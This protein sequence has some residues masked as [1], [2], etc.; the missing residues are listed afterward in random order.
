[1]LLED[2]LRECRV[3]PVVNSPD[4]ETTVSL[5]Q[6]LAAGG[7]KG[8]EITLRTPSALASLQAVKEAVPELT[9]AAGTITNA[10][11]IENAVQAGADFCFSPGISEEILVGAKEA[12]VPLVPGVAS[13]SEIMLGLAHDISLFKLFPATVVGGVDMLKALGG[14]FPDIMFCP[15]GGLNESNYE[16]FLALPNVTCCGGSWM[17]SKSLVESES[18]DEI[19]QLARKIMQAGAVN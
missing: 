12:G 1:M 10:R 3:M 14:P 7:M 19:E 9:V 13:A 16:A 6:A 5:A 11:D 15:T 17:A 2:T 8:I 18:W 4:V